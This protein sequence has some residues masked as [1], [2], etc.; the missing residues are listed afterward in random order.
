LRDKVQACSIYREQ[1][2]SDHAPYIVDYAE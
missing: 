2:F 1:R